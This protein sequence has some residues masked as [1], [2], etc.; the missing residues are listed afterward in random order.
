MCGE[1]ADAIKRHQQFV[2][3]CRRAFDEMARIISKASKV[4]MHKLESLTKLKLDNTS[5]L[6]AD[7]ARTMRHA[8]LSG[9]R[10]LE[11]MKEQL[12]RGDEFERELNKLI[13]LTVGV[14]RAGNGRKRGNAG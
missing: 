7:V 9:K 4:A 2:A 11:A 10:T 13:A 8:L 14:E 12:K 3:D 1:A 5:F 6:N